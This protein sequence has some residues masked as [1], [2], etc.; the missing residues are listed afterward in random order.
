M[1]QP[2]AEEREYREQVK[3]LV[4]ALSTG[5]PAVVDEQLAVINK[6]P[7]PKSVRFGIRLGR[8]RSDIGIK[9]QS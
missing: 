7:K 4:K 3:Q 8:Q 5:D 6:Q 1:S 9:N 2:T